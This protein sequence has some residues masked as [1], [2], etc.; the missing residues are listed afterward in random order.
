MPA[1]QVDYAVS[2]IMQL[3]QSD[4][5]VVEELTMEVDVRARGLSIVRCCLNNETVLTLSGHPV[6]CSEFRP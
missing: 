4:G 5:A 6:F 1:T 3:K 2:L